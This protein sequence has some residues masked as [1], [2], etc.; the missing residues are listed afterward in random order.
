VLLYN[1]RIALKS[2]KRNRVLSALILGG[3]ALGIGVS[4]LCAALRHSLAKDPIPSKSEVLH[5][6]RLDSWDP[7][8]G[9]PGDP[10][11]R[12]PTQIT[13]RDM[14]GIMKSDIPVRQ[15]GM[16]KANL[17]VYPGGGERPAKRLVRMTFAD[18]FPMF[19]VPFKYGR[20]WDRQADAGPEAVVVL[21]EE[22]NEQIFGGADSVGRTLRIEDRDFKV[23]GVLDT[24]RPSVK[25]F[26]L[27]QNAVQP[28]ELLYM[29]FNWLRPMNIR[30]S[31]NN[32]GWGPN[33]GIPG[34][35]GLY[36]SETCWIQFWVELPDEAAVARY[37]DFLA[38][39][40][41][42]QKKLGRFQRPLNNRVT[43]VTDWMTEQNIVPDEIN[44]MVVV[45]LLFL[46]VCALNL[47]GLLLS[48]FLARAS[49]VGVRR[50]LGARRIDIFV[51]HIVEC[52]LVG[53]VGGVLGVVL[54][55]GG[56]AVVN[57]W[58]KLFAGRADLFSID[59]A[60]TAAAAGMSLLAGLVA[61]VYPAWRIC[62]I[63][64]AIHL[65]LQ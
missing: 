20:P 54:S 60:T 39:Y 44:A 30:T 56:I 43:K 21:S 10:V 18:F 41:G 25:F 7:Q 59:L 8:R 46:A 31:G 63:P 22:A 9:Y 1:I 13:W 34:L 6:V 2:L 61:G 47:T 58:V 14:E 64:P 48:K 3:I 19:E 27:T 55:I 38:A 65:K 53:L 51:Q 62:R 32:D 33:T 11:G 45:S 24:W 40:V 49:E 26:D 42:E 37:R 17:T 5:Y 57:N 28:P 12:P 50:A 36:A 52:E 23:V 4:T 15:A 35:D 29:P 16:F